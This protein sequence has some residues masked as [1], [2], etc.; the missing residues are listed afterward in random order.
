MISRR[1]A[2]KGIGASLLA[3]LGS[4]AMAKGAQGQ[5][6]ATEAQVPVEDAER[7]VYLFVQHASGGSFRPNPAMPG[8]YTLTLE[9]VGPDT[10]FFSDRPARDAGAVPNG[11]FLD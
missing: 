5:E 1:I 10:I 9:G 3:G 4:W 2:L 8:L 7:T 11:P 6:A